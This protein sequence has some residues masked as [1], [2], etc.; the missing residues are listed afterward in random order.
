MRNVR[1]KVVSGVTLLIFL[2][3]AAPVAAKSN[4]VEI[5]HKGRVIEVSLVASIYHILVHGDTLEGGAGGCL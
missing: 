5:N 4:R 1:Q 3:F 2:L